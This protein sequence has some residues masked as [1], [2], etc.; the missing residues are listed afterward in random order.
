MTSLIQDH[1]YDASG[2]RLGQL[3]EIILD[4]RTGCVRYA[5]LALG[6]FLGMGQKRVAIPWSGLTPEVNYHRCIVDVPLMRL[7]AVPVPENDPWLQRVDR[8]WANIAARSS[9]AERTNG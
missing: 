4:A 8:T 6:G 9:I 7:T 3:K 2:N 5:V 1:V